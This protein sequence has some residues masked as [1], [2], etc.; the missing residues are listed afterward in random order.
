M[1]FKMS[2]GATPPV[3][4]AKAAPAAPATKKAPSRARKGA[5]LQAKAQALFEPPADKA[6]ADR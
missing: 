4:P 6:K 5:S 1:A 3:V 2:Y